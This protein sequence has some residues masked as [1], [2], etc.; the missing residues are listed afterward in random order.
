MQLAGK[1]DVALIPYGG[2]TNVTNS[3]S[4]SPKETRMVVSLDMT[5]MNK[6]KWV[7][8]INQVACVEAG[9]YGVDLEKELKNYGVCCG[10]EPV[11]HIILRMIYDV[12]LI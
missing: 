9:I 6:V 4:I 5:R 7:D 3:L 12:G 10:H 2:G 11:Y 8:R 1:H